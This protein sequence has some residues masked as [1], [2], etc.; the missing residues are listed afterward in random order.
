MRLVDQIRL[1]RSSCPA[2][3]DNRVCLIEAEI[4]RIEGRYLDATDLY[5]RAIHSARE[6]GFLHHEAICL[7]LTSRFYE[8]G[9]EGYTYLEEP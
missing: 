8:S 1:V 2:N 9:L 3:F 4:A 5:E 7:E 6:N